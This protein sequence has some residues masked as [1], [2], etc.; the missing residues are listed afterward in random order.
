MAVGVMPP[1]VADRG[2][3]RRLL[4]ALAELD[5]GGVDQLWAL[6]ADE[7]GGLM[8]QLERVRRLCEA[9][10]VAVLAEAV[11]R[12]ETS[13]PTSGPAARLAARDW[14]SRACSGT[15]LG[16]V[17]PGEVARLVEVTLAVTATADAACLRDAVVDGTVRLRTARVC[18]DEMARLGPLLV[19][20]AAGA[21][22]AGYTDLARV[23]N[24]RLVH[25]LRPAMLARYG[26]D[27][28]LEREHDHARE[29]VELT[30]GTRDGALVRYR[31]TL[32]LEAH[33]V[34]EAA[35]GPLSAP[36]PEPD[37]SM[38]SRP[39]G[40]RRANALLDLVQRAVRDGCTTPGA[41]RARILVTTSIE[42]L[43]RA[44][45]LPPSPPSGEDPG[46][47]SPTAEVLAT[48]ADGALLAGS[49]LGRLACDGLVH[50]LVFGTTGEILHY[51]TEVRLF[52]AS[53]RHALTLRD[54]GCTF[55]GCDAPAA[56]TRAHHLTH[57]LHGGPT[58][59][60]NGALL[61]SRHHTLVHRN[62]LHGRVDPDTN[63]VEWD[64]T[65]GS[66]DTRTR[67]GP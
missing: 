65:P 43:R 32:D 31:L 14:A 34:L 54:R 9:A 15:G 44:A 11:T 58:T 26:R 64:L 45:G 60:T 18:L 20:G 23:G 38:D 53:Q 13:G 5:F 42:D 47:S 19:P 16:P 27:D 37:G 21:V 50:G 10:Q 22:W 2:A 12:G 24:L 55:P 57:W 46:P 35:L 62:R 66:Y 59:L 33:A 25:Q 30:A 8:T 29:H 28:A 40:R 56:W 41:G 6:S 36:R 1:P 51:G 67:D 61:C 63:T 52:T 48:T 49:V 4:G 7:L 39:V 17:D 3:P